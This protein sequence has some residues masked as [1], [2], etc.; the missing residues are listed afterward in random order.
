MGEFVDPLEGLTGKVTGDSKGV[1]AETF[2]MGPDV[3]EETA[4]SP[5]AGSHIV[6]VLLLRVVRAAGALGVQGLR[7][8]PLVPFPAGCLTGTA[9]ITLVRLLGAIVLTA[10]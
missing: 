7:G 9:G 8:R 2:E 1:A 5:G 4:Y 3:L 10:Q 6:V